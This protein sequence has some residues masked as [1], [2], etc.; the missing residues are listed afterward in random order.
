MTR[1]STVQLLSQMPKCTQ[2]N[3][4]G[5]RMNDVALAFKWWPR[6][7][8]A[9]SAALQQRCPYIIAHDVVGSSSGAKRYACATSATVAGIDHSVWGSAAFYAVV[10]ASVP[11]GLQVAYPYFDFDNVSVPPEELLR[12]VEARGFSQVEVYCTS[13]SSFHVHAAG[14]VLTWTE[15]K[16]HAQH[17]GAD[18]CVYHSG[19]LFRLPGSRKLSKRSA[20]KYH[21]CGHPLP[22]FV[23][24]CTVVGYVALR[25]DHTLGDAMRKLLATGAGSRH[26]VYAPHANA[27]PGLRP[28]RCGYCPL[29]CKHH[30]GDN[31]VRWIRNQTTS[32]W[33]VTCWGAAVHGIRRMAVA[34]EFARCPLCQ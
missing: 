26:A 8:D 11:Q 31:T 34:D 7:E 10:G 21:V 17:L 28:H 24:M 15:L 12:R 2:A 30:E 3:A 14:P 20:P 27:M 29:C 22:I 16:E 19:R 1:R 6:L 13:E 33:Y 18:D 23:T 4:V 25:V 9:K 5:P 32:S